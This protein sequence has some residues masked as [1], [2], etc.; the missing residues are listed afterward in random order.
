MFAASLQMS[1][2]LIVVMGMI[3]TYYYYYYSWALVLYCTITKL[4]DGSVIS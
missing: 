2:W 4:T 3:I 1:G